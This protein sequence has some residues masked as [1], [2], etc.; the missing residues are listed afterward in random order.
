MKPSDV[1]RLH[2]TDITIKRE[3]NTQKKQTSLQSEEEKA[4]LTSTLCIY[5]NGRLSKVLV[6]S[7]HRLNKPFNTHLF[8]FCCW[9]FGFTF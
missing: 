4:A 1:D 7:A 5:A 2:F 8:L 9:H 3:K 6:S